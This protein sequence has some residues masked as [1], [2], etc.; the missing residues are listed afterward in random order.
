MYKR[1]PR[2]S[3]F[4][5]IRS[6]VLQLL[7]KK[8]LARENELLCKPPSDEEIEKTVLG[9][10]KGKLPRGMELHMISLKAIGSLWVTAARAWW[11]ASREML[12]F[13]SI[14]SMALSK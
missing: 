7:T 3:S 2:V 14:W 5:A 13:P 12:N 10:P 4:T 6:E 1:D 11:M 8:F 9:F